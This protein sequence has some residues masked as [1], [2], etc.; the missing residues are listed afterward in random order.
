MRGAGEIL[1]T[2]M[3]LRYNL[4]QEAGIAILLRSLSKKSFLTSREAGN[5]FQIALQIRN[6]QKKLQSLEGQFDTC[7]ETIIDISIKLDD[8]VSQNYRER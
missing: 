1:N 3:L 6:L 8:K 5:E 7:T 4:K 2:G